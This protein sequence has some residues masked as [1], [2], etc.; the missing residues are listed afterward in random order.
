VSMRVNMPKRSRVTPASHLHA[1]DSSPMK[2]DMPKSPTFTCAD[3]HP[4]PI[5]MHTQG[6]REDCSPGRERSGT[7]APRSGSSDEPIPTGPLQ[8]ATHPVFAEEQVG[9]L[10]VAVHDVRLV[11][12]Q[13]RP[14]RRGAGHQ[15]QQLVH[16]PHRVGRV[17]DE[18]VQGPPTCAVLAG[19]VRC[20]CTSSLLLNLYIA[21]MRAAGLI[22]IGQR[23]DAVLVL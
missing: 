2:R 10:E 13:V 14:A 15:R 20:A 11:G 22:D 21:G 5:S 1:P 3:R 23:S 4:S 16:V 19:P 9:G 6:S 7:T 12:V 18:H 17:V 8:R